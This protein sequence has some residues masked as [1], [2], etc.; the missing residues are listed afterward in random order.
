MALS[1][2]HGSTHWINHGS[3][4]SL[5]NINPVTLM[6]WVSVDTL[7]VNGERDLLFSK[8]TINNEDGTGF[9]VGRAT[10]TPVMLALI[11]TEDIRC[12]AQAATANFAL[13]GINKW[14][15]VT[16][17][18]EVGVSPRLL[19]GD[20]ATAPAEPSSYLFQD[21]GTGLVTDNSSFDQII[22]NGRTLASVW[23][24]GGDVAFV[25]IV[26]GNLT[27][28]QIIEQWMRPHSF[29]PT[30]SRLFVHYG[31]NGS[32]SQ[33]DWSGNGNHGTLVGSPGRVAHVPLM[34]GFGYDAALSS[35]ATATP[36]PIP[37]TVFQRRFNPLILR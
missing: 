23:Q 19:V 9:F 21:A 16:A 3:G 5:D 30:I 32:G 11:E 33:I 1:L 18:L 13:Y 6:A 27:N 4:T 29:G 2:V 22:G 10:P 14:I 20:L 28:D 12:H 31:F 35:V 34:P 8:Q 15:F 36:T 7:E 25:H 37:H 26:A 17:A 24:M